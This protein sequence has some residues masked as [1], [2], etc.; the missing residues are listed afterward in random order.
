MG[1]GRDDGGELAENTLA[2]RIDR[3]HPPAEGHYGSSSVA[4][5]VPDEG[6]SSLDARKRRMLAALTE[7]ELPSGW[8]AKIN[9]TPKLSDSKSRYVSVQVSCR[10]VGCALRSIQG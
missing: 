8:T 3:G 9:L 10:S 1:G 5:A 7:T 6:D 2:E 4:V